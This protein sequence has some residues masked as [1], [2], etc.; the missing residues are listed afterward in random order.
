LE[1]TDLACDY[2]NGLFEVLSFEDYIRITKE[3][4]A[5]IPPDVVAHRLT[6]DGNKRHLIAPLWS[7]DKKRVINAMKK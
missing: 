7:A 6:G 2:E 5:L 3:C 1:N 4:V